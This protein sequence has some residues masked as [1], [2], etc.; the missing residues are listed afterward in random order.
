MKNVSIVLTAEEAM[1]IVAA[2]CYV[3][4][5]N[6]ADESLLSIAQYLIREAT[7]GE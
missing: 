2:L 6:K 5:A 4:G 1:Q 3:V 7:E